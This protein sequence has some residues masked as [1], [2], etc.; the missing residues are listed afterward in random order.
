MTDDKLTSMLEQAISD[1]GQTASSFAQGANERLTPEAFHRAA[2]MISEETI[3]PPVRLYNPRQFE[4]LRDDAEAFGTDT[5]DP[6]WDLVVMHEWRQY[7]RFEAY[8]RSMGW[9]PSDRPE[10]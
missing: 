5:S 1:F 4:R 8:L 9:K 10:Q 6:N 3:R 2:K 7:W